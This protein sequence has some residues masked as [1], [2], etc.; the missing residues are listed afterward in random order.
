VG[1]PVLEGMKA[2][3]LD[4]LQS[5]A[6]SFPSGAYGFWPEDARPAWA[7]KVPPDV[8]DTALALVELVRHRRIP[9]AE[10]LRTLC[11]VILPCRVA[12]H[13]ERVLPPWVHAGCFETWIEPRGGGRGRQIVD[14]CVNANVAA[15]MAYL[16]A[17]HL[18]GYEE[19][20]ATIDAGLAWAAADRARLASL[21]PFYPSP[22]GFAEALAHAVECGASAL[23]HAAR[24]VAHLAQERGEDDARC[25]SSAY[26]HVA[27][28]CPALEEARALSAAPH[29]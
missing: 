24:H 10:A 6:C 26:G 27:W 23:A 29:G 9:S 7:V 13:E 22:G 25:C 5:C 19:A 17:R 11:V 8:D 1:D 4:F 14:A 12:R 28:R 3:A 18:P 15:L 2:R 21:T 16:G 20:L